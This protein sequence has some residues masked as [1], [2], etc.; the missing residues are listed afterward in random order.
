MDLSDKGVFDASFPLLLSE[1]ET[2]AAQVED[3][4]SGAKAVD[5]FRRQFCLRPNDSWSSAGSRPGWPSTNNCV[6]AMNNRFKE[7]C[8]ERNMLNLSTMLDKLENWVEHRSLITIDEK[9]Q[10]AANTD[11]KMWGH[12]LAFVESDQRECTMH[13][14][15][16][17][18]PL[19]DTALVPSG[20]TMRS[21][22]GTL[23]YELGLFL[24]LL[25]KPSHSSKRR[26][27]RLQIQRFFLN[28]FYNLPE[29]CPHAQLI[30]L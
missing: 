19:V 15:G 27:V 6:E 4:S 3:K 24:K 13:R 9:F 7:E 22:E 30:Q 14:N 20:H 11:K 12:A 25:Q 1:V 5:Y 23:T 21:C 17:Y 2:R 29:R 26:C 28:F 10:T 18:N 16:A 8:T